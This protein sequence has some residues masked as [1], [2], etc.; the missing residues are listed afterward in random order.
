[1]KIVYFKIVYLNI[2]I[3]G[4]SDGVPPKECVCL[5]KPGKF[6][7]MLPALNKEP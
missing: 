4:V 7:L 2:V 5:A 3:D 1:M 6:L